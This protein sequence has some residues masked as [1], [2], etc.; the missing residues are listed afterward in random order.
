MSREDSD[1]KVSQGQPAL[2][3]LSSTRRAPAAVRP[4]VATKSTRSS[5]RDEKRDALGYR[6]GSQ[7]KTLSVAGEARDPALRVS[8]FPARQLNGDGSGE[9]ANGSTA[10]PPGTFRRAHNYAV[11]TCCFR[12]RK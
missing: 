6:C 1:G 2:R 4:P 9:C 3:N 8:C 7:E 5:L 11:L 10:N 12:G